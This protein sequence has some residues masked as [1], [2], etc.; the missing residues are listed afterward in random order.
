MSH[1]VG[2]MTNTLRAGATTGLLFG[3]GG[4]ATTSHAI[5][6]SRDDRF[7]RG[8]PQAFSVQA[9]ADASRGP[10]PPVNET[11]E[12]AA[13][14]E[15]YTVFYGRDG[16]PG[17]GVVVARTPA[18]ER[19]LAHVPGDDGDVIGFLTSGAVEP[20]GAA[21]VVRAGEDGLMRWRAG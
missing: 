4:Y 13:T 3:N 8:G 20:V 11:H 19:T 9:E 14:I 10:A 16:Q 2:A 7:A 18:G 5:L 12:G 21:G 15:S 17:S 1:A 6:L